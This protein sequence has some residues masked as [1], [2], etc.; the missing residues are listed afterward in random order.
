VGVTSGPFVV[1]IDPAFDGPVARIGLD[2]ADIVS[3]S[4]E[5]RS[6]S[7]SRRDG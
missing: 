1:V 7:S 6:P 5:M 4:G 3:R 2:I